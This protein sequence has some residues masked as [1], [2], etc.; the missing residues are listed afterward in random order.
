MCCMSGFINHMRLK[1]TVTH[2]K[3]P[4]LRSLYILIAC[5][6][7]GYDKP[8]GHYFYVKFIISKICLERRG[9]AV[10]LL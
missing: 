10:D 9:I 8:R 2:G 1:A 5:L 7:K 4:A 3:D 6:V